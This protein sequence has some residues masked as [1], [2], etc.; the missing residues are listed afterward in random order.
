MVYLLNFF[1]RLSITWVPS[2]NHG[3]KFDVTIVSGFEN[4]I[5]IYKFCQN[6]KILPAAHFSTSFGN[7]IQTIFLS[8]VTRFLVPAYFVLFKFVMAFNFGKNV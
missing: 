5:K 7:L 3:D 8:D 4:N 6:Y 1:K 2:F